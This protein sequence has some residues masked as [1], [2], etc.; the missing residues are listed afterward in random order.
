M[1]QP[2]YKA[3]K[4]LTCL[5]KQNNRNAIYLKRMKRTLYLLLIVICTYNPLSANDNT[6]SLPHFEQARQQLADMLNGKTPLSYERAVFITENA[7]WDNE[8]SEAEFTNVLNL[9]T[10]YIQQLYRANHQKSISD[11]KPTLLKT[12]AQQLQQ[13]EKALA[14]YAIYLYMTDTTYYIDSAH[15]SYHLPNTYSQ[16]DPLGTLNFS[17]TQVHSLLY[18]PMQQG[19]C[20]AQAA[21]FKIYSD[22]L[23]SNAALCTAPGHIYISH[24][25]A[26]GV[27]YN[28]EPATGNFPGAGTLA[29]L[30]YSTTDAIKSNI[31]M[32]QLDTKQAIALC[33]VYLAKGYEHK[34]GEEASAF[35]L[36]C[37]ELALQYDSLCLNAMLLQAEV[38]EAQLM[39]QNKPVAQLQG[40]A[41][42][43]QYQNLLRSMYATG[44]RQMPAAQRQL[45]MDKIRG[46]DVA[47]AS[48]SNTGRNETP[49]ASL[50][51]GVLDEEMQTKPTE[52]YGN[53]VFNTKTLSVI[54]FA[55][56]NDTDY[57]IDLVTFALSVDP[58][59]AK[60]A[61]MSP[62][63]AF[64]DNPIIYV[65]ADGRENTIYLVYL[66]DANT[67]LTVEELNGIVA[68]ANE[69]FKALG[70]NTRVEVYTGSTPLKNSMVD[71][72][73]AIVALGSVENVKKYTESNITGGAWSGQTSPNNEGW[74]GGKDNPEITQPLNIDGSGGRV[75]MVDANSLPA[76]ASESGLT[77]VE[78]GSHIIVH[79]AG[80]TAGKDDLKQP[81]TTS[82]GVTTANPAIMMD[83]QSTKDYMTGGNPR[84]SKGK[85][86]FETI[87]KDNVPNSTYR[88]AMI[89]RYQS[90]DKNKPHNPRI[91]TIT[92]KIK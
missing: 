35:A 52:I 54:A 53:T 28:I 48:M 46:E 60:Y 33:L 59:A 67:K 11:F 81:T 42:F 58:L 14:N 86:K 23:Q 84:W 47:W 17:N 22:R 13:Y 44:Y 50:S 25:D 1:Q 19:N 76:S 36:S 78:L 43:N 87:Y 65:D 62:Y 57:P 32:R 40:N 4:K 31:A 75:I 74:T 26:D 20:Y 8:L 72:S 18:S 24:T 6:G 55:T 92:Q 2:V 70:L 3:N 63:M 21:L 89:D 30:T 85:G 91:K 64:A 61:S 39:A 69:Q 82:G 45:I 79:G 66:P 83:G 88:K 77:T 29:T 10:A 9:H 15:I 68:K 49:K 12:A 80:H 16:T 56:A 34:T 41:Q 38:L 73:D 37:A 71:K 90:G 51:M 27:Q 5:L 7:Y